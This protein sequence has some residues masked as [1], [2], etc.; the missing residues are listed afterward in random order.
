MEGLCRARR[1]F[2]RIVCN[3]YDDRDKK[4]FLRIA[5]EKFAKVNIESI[6]TLVN[7]GNALFKLSE[8]EEDEN[9]QRAY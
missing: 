3:K 1:N 2:T 7:W 4:N 5:C 6:E 8:I 9:E